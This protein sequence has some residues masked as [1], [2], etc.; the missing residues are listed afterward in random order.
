MVERLLSSATAPP[1]TPVPPD[2]RNAGADPAA[3]FNA[4]LAALLPRVK[5]AM[6][7]AGAAGND[8]KLRASEAGMHARK[9]EFGP[10][11]AL[12][13]ELET[14]LA[15]AGQPG[16]PPTGD[17]TTGEQTE[18]SPSIGPGM[19]AWQKARSGA[20]GQLKA[21]QTHIGK[22]QHPRG[23]AAL[24]LLKSI[25][26]NLSAR[27]DSAAQV[28][29]LRRYLETD[30]ILREAER[31]NGFGLTVELRKPLLAALATLEQEMTA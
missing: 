30:D 14:L 13:D 19:A 3:A 21:L 22:M 27:P 18:P 5:A 16:Q 20:L 7:V 12:L 6:A 10:A 26:A 23:N 31:P 9:R 1:T 8:L 28:A 15:Q 4:R 11:Q 29:E 24:I 17:S 2:P 25:Q